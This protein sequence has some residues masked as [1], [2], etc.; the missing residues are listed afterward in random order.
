M[1]R[2]YTVR[3]IK[4]RKLSVLANAYKTPEDLISSDEDVDEYSNLT[5]EKLYEAFE[6]FVVLTMYY[7]F[8]YELVKFVDKKFENLTLSLIAI[9]S[10]I[11]YGTPFHNMLLED[12]DSIELKIL[13][14]LDPDLN[15]NGL[16]I[17][18]KTA[19]TNDIYNPGNLNKKDLQRYFRNKFYETICKT[20][21]DFKHL[22]RKN[23]FDIF[24]E[25]FLLENKAFLKN[26]GAWQIRKVE[27][28]KSRSTKNK[29]PIAPSLE[30]FK[31]ALQRY[32]TRR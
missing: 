30:N 11:S 9:Q 3:I 31:K 8:R 23:G 26:I 32:K 10:Q 12:L 14:N 18:S 24:L 15:E 7:F 1:N 27:L 25:K 21:W 2:K 6:S 22:K 29:G 20:E 13:K 28:Q 16:G 19:L 5:Q 4:N 17:L